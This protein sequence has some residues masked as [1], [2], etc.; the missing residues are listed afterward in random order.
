MNTRRQHALPRSH[1]G[2]LTGALLWLGSVLIVSLAH[3]GDCPDLLRHTFTSLQTRQPQ[4]LCQYQGKVVLVVNTASKCGYTS[5]YEG[6]ESLYRQYRD[7]GL[8]VLGFP[9]NDFAGQEPGSNAQIAK[10]CRLTYS[11]EFPMF[12]KSSVVGSPRNPLYAQLNQKTGVAPGWNFHKYL[13]DATGQRVVAFEPAVTPKD[14]R[15]M[16][17]LQGMLAARQRTARQD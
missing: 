14:P 15:L 13:I 16:Q 1:H 11:V 3:A 4:N 5:Q 9:S 17:E 7:K 2:L 6:L 8:V 10:F 12:E